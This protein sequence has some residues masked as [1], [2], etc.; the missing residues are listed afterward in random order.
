MHGEQA[1][2]L[3]G[4]TGDAETVRRAFEA[5]PVIMIEYAGRDHTV[6]AINAAFR[7]IS[8]H[9]HDALVGKPVREALP[10][11][12][13][14]QVYEMFDEVYATGREQVAREWRLQIPPG[15]DGEQREIF[16]DF[17][18]FPVRDANGAVVGQRA[19]ATDVTSRVIERQAAR[20]V[21]RRPSAATSR[22]VM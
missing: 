12:A 13:G 8:G 1:D 2:D 9:E 22:H 15:P 7:R 16:L 17:H 18:L 10:E 6:A 14:Q 20:S 4:T 19:F 21:R 11:L 3:D 5:M